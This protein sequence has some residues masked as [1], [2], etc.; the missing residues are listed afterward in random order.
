MSLKLAC[1]IP[2]AT[3]EIPVLYCLNF[4]FDFVWFHLHNPFFWLL[5]SPRGTAILLVKVFRMKI[6][7]IL[8][9]KF[10]FR[11]VFYD[12]SQ[13]RIFIFIFLILNLIYKGGI[14]LFK[15]GDVGLLENVIGLKLN[16]PL[17]RR[18]RGCLSEGNASGKLLWK[19]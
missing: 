12:P 8:I 14:H 11:L 18:Q 16:L 13:W 6:R 5:Q 7:Y 10:L 3:D 1:T 9:W 15:N 17:L 2:D 19:I 4:S